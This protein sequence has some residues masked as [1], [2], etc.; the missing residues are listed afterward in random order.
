MCDRKKVLSVNNGN[1]NTKVVFIAEAPGR[2]GAEC[3]GIPLYGD[4]T[5]ENFEILLGNIGWKREDIFISNAILCNPQDKNGNNSTPT[6]EEIK[7]CSYYLEMTL[8]L[9]NPDIIVTLGAKALE[10][11]KY[12]KDHKFVLRDCV[13]QKLSWNNRYIFPIYH[14]GPRATI[15]RGI[16]K[17]RS[18]FIKLSHIIDPIKGIKKYPEGIK[19]LSNNNEKLDSRLLDMVILIIKELNTVSLFK[20]TKLLYLID[21]NHYKKYGNSISG[22]IYLRMQDGPWVPTLRNYTKEYNEK[23]FKVTFEKKKP[24]L[25]R[26]SNNYLNRL[27]DEQKL[28]INEIIQIYKYFTEANL[29]IAAYKTIPMQYIL[30]QER[31]GRNMSRIPVLYKDLSILEMDKEKIDTNLFKE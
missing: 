4:K 10:A 30:E 7:N 24:I 14:M 12:I 2:L 31:L 28:Y 16:I 9:I 6:L 13:A 20:L 22:S 3:T 26:I 1:L 17:Q 29:K 5:G 18:D 27:T 21:Y 23:L 8:E 11:L 25:T 15:H 19:K